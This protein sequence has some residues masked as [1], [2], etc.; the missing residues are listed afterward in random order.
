LSG[1]LKFVDLE[2]LYKDLAEHV[3]DGDLETNKAK[4]LFI[5][6]PEYS[7]KIDNLNNEWK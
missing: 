2:K 3:K 7:S 4:D 1:G 5:R 6:L